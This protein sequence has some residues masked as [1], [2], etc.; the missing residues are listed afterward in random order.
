MSPMQ[1]GAVRSFLQRQLRVLAG[2]S[3]VQRKAASKLTIQ[4]G[5]S[6]HAPTLGSVA[7]TRHA[8]YGVACLA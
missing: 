8:I 4:N 6:R 3:H 2:A 1:V 5:P 7:D